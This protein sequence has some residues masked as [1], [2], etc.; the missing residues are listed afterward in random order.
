MS[1]SSIALN[2]APTHRG[3]LIGARLFRITVTASGEPRVTN[4]GTFHPA[5]SPS[6]RNRSKATTV[7][8][9]CATTTVSTPGSTAAR[10]PVSMGSRMPGLRR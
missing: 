5:W 7:P 1:A 6:R 8:R 9:E 10:T 4:R 3:R 2:H